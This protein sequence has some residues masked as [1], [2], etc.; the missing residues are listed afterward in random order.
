VLVQG[1]NTVWAVPDDPGA[2]YTLDLDRSSLVV[3]L[4]ADPP[5]SGDE[6]RRRGWSLGGEPTRLAVEPIRKPQEA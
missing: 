1:S 4:V 5:G 3:P 6:F 2:T